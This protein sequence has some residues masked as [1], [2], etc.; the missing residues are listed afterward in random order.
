MGNPHLKIKYKIM[1][2]MA[3]PHL[4]IKYEIMLFMAIPKIIL[5]HTEIN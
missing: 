5:W 1:L 4:K 2:F 3:N